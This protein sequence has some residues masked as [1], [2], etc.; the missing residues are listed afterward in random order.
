MK[1]WLSTFLT[2]Q[3][4]KSDTMLTMAVL[5][6]VSYV[7][8]EGYALIVQH[9]HFQAF[10]YATG[11]GAAIAA[12]S[13]GMGYRTAQMNISSSGVTTGGSGGGNGTS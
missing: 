3:N 6:V 1:K 2:N 11:L 5:G 13:A 9:Q 12:A 7:G 4:G 8:F 10:S